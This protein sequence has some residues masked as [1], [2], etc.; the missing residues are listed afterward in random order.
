MIVKKSKL[1]IL[2]GNNFIKD[3][4]PNILTVAKKMKIRGAYEY[5]K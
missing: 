5:K 3:S 1:G 4:T 2:D